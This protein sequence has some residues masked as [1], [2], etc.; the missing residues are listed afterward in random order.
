MNDVT[1][2]E[3]TEDQLTKIVLE[4]RPDIPVILR[5]GNS[6][7]L[8][9]EIATETR[10]PTFAMRHLPGSFQAVPP[11][12]SAAAKKPSFNGHH[13]LEETGLSLERACLHGFAAC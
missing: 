4:I 3:M 1:M 10:I 11:P 2:S 13:A 7:S 8:S 12:P 9:E 5:T 6:K